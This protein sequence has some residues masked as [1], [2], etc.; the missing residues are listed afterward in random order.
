MSAAADEVMAALADPTRWRVLNLLAE[1]GEGTA[2]TLAGELPV[3]RVAVVKHLA[4]LD[5]AGLVE[6]APPGPRGLL[7]RAA[8]AP[9]GGGALDGRARL[10]VGPAPGRPQA[11]G[12]G[13]EAWPF[14]ALLP[15]RC[16][17]ARDVPSRPT[18]RRRLPAGRVYDD[19]PCS[20][21]TPPPADE[22]DALTDQPIEL[23]D[24]APFEIA[25]EAYDADVAR[26]EPFNR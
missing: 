2:T 13:R 1:R 20:S 10:A 5:R 8:R 4:V 11:P 24:F 18:Q 15:P 7:P 25:P 3:S 17:E 22:H 14:Q 9:G 23:A 19:G 12:R 26:L 16:D 6:G 21:T